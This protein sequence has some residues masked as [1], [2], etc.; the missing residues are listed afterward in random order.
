MSTERDT[1]RIVRSWLEEGVT[2]L[3]DRVLDSVL[4]QLPTTPQRRSRWPARRFPPMFNLARFASV[5]AAFA[6]AAVVGLSLVPGMGI[7][8]PPATRTATASPAPT[9]SLAPT[10][11]TAL[12]FRSL[13]AGTYVSGATFRV[14][15]TFTLPSGWQG[16]VP[17]PNL[18]DLTHS[19]RN[20]ALSFELFEMVVA[21]PCNYP[22]G[23][24]DPGPTVDDLAT[25]LADMPNIEATSPVDITID[26]YRGKHLTLTAPDSFRDCTLEPGENHYLMWQLPLGATMTM[27]PSQV[28]QVQILDVDGE[29]LVIAVPESPDY[30]DEQ[31]AEVQAIVA[32]IRLDPQD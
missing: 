26:G 28:L 11:P 1:T 27:T 25:A 24:L 10:L 19:F 14:P 30:T 12:D 3:P 6:V 31:R 23:L 16:R 5:A 13:E 7:G 9:T 15:V 29:R 22:D 17:G 4:D 2:A 8:G 18:V 32:S 21:D 20:S